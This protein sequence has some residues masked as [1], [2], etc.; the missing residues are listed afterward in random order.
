MNTRSIV[1]DSSHLSATVT[2]LA[3]AAQRLAIAGA[4]PHPAAA[5]GVA[6]TGPRG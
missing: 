3:G 2:P 4:P 6:G 1:R 5:D